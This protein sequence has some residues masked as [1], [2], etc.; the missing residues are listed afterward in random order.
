MTSLRIL[1]QM[2]K[3]DYLERVR[4]YSFLITVLVSIFIVFKFIPSSNENYL[5]LSLNNMRGIYN[6]DWVGSAIAIL[7]SMLLSLP[8][9]FLVKNAIERDVQTGV[10][11]IIAT[12]P[13]TRWMYTMGKMWSNFVLLMSIV[14]VLIVSALA[15]QLIR[16]ESYT[17][18][19]LKLSLP[20]L[21]STLPT[22]ALVASIAILFES[23]PLLRKGL[24]NLIYF[25]L[26]IISLKFSTTAIHS[27][28]DILGISPILTRLSSEANAGLPHSNGGHV[29]GMSPLK[30]DLLTYDWTGVH[31]TM[32]MFVER[33]IWL[34]VAVVIVA[35]ASI[36]FHRF[37]LTRSSKINKKGKPSEFRKAEPHIISVHMNDS[38][39]K[40][41]P[42]T[43][44][45]GRSHYI[46]ILVME[47][48]LML[49][50]LRF[51]WYLIAW[52]LIVLGLLLPM[53]SVLKFVAPIT[54]VWPI[55]IWSAMGTNE[56][57]HRTHQLMFTATHPI[58]N[59]FIVLWLAGIIVAYLTGSGAIIHFLIAGEWESLKAMAVGGLFI[60][61]LAVALGVWS[62]NGKI[63]QVI[64]MLMWYL[65]PLNKL[66]VMDF[67]GASQQ[68]LDLGLYRYYLLATAIL[69]MLAVIGRMR[70]VKIA[71]KY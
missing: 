16:G 24:G 41:T 54:W 3:A 53:E 70:Q 30:G 59:Q 28:Q 62:G 31:W 19:L 50:G 6:S 25:V 35:V 20:F 63:F 40:L 60:P 52:V 44:V 9:F 5:T 29:S 7:A 66:E 68:S 71:T 38:G 56:T 48:R 67:M 37:D 55:L 21:Y 61:T 57:Y 2:M 8:A 10:G 32:Q 23:V 65:G 11:Q 26:W 64:F 46:T 69:L 45:Q 15:M 27:S 13:I 36:F 39:I 14:A 33:Y 18:E 58:R 49:K 43:N 42:Y 1:F 34:A 17:V 4:R 22:M 51:W 47:L 12:T